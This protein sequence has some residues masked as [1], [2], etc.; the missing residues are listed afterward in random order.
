MMNNYTEKYLFIL[1]LHNSVS[2][3]TNLTIFYFDQGKRHGFALAY[4]FDSIIVTFTICYISNKL[5]NGYQEFLRKLEMFE[6]SSSLENLDNGLISRLNSM[7]SS[8]TFR[9]LGF[10]KLG[11]EFFISNISFILT[12]AVILIQTN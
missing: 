6:Q 5:G 8:W 11:S 1:I 3:V 7:E 4:L 12:L 2:C 9:A 10:Y